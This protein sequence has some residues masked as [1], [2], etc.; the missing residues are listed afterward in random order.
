MHTLG[1]AFRPWT[2][3]KAIADGPAILDYIRETAARG[4]HRRARSASAT[5]SRG[6]AG[7]RERRALDGRGRARRRRDGRADL[8][9][10]CSCCTRLLPTTTQGYTPEFAG[11]ERFG[12]PIVHP[13]HWPEDLDYAGKR[14]VVI[15]S[16][17]TAVTLVPGDGRAGRA[18]D[19]AAALAELRPRRCRPRPDRQRLRRAAR[20]RS[21]PTAIARWKNISS[22][23]AHLPAQPAPAAL[24]RALI[25]ARRRAGS[26]PRATT[27]TRTS[28]RAT[29]R[30]TSACASCPTATCSGA[31]ARGARLGRHR[32]DRDVHRAR[33]PARVRARSSR[34]TSSSPPPGCTCSRSAASARRRRREVDAP[35]DARLQGH[36][37]QRRAELRLRGRLHERVLDAEGRPRQRVRRAA[38]SRTWTPHGYDRRA[39][40]ND[41][42]TVSARPLLD[43][44]AGMCCA[45]CDVPQGGFQ[46]RGSSA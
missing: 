46:R 33:H 10:S 39:P 23:T 21:A 17:A 31:I 3:D 45:R 41:D 42:P 30:G 25:R 13:Q 12:G 27:S 35:R 14:V 20:R 19:D 5:A 37:A 9:A 43:F 1:Y 38:C 44:P 32:H 34:P 15:G 18:R 6:A 24:V 4:R 40:V 29:T 28:S 36:D 7:R 22:Q 8:R 2:R 11:A 16:G 26:C